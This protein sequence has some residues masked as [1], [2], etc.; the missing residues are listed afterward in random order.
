MVPTMFISYI[1]V[2]CY[3]DPYKYACTLDWLVYFYFL[4]FKKIG[5]VKDPKIILLKWKYRSNTKIQ[6]HGVKIIKK[7]FVEIFLFYLP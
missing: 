5:P 2:L 6:T 3:Q 4:E 1:K 7:T